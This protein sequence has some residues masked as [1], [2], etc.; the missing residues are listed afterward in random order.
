VTAESDRREQRQGSGQLQANTEAGREGGQNA[1]RFFQILLSISFVGFSWLAFMIV[2]EFGHALTA[3]ATGGAVV[4]HPLQISW[5]SFARNPH[6]RLVT[7]GGPVL[8]E[9]L[10]LFFLAI[11]SVFRLPGIYLFR[12]FAGFCLIAN[13]LYLFVDSFSR[14]GDGGTL[15]RSGASQWQLLLFGL[16]SAPI[17]FQFWH[18]LGRHFGLGRQ[19]AEVDRRAA[20]VSFSLL[21]VTIVM[22]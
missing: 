14:G 11:A 9:V 18:G 13:G 19:A 20:V 5:T 4:L 16:V 15:L 1:Q 7:W 10:P 3:W 22:N 21:A 8:G 12:F 2:H 6:P 17:G